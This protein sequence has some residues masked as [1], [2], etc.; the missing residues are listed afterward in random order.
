MRRLGLNLITGPANAGKVALLLRRYL[1]VLAEEPYLIVPNRSDVEERERELLALQP[2]LLAGWIGTFDDLFKRIARSGLESRRVASDSQ[3]ALIVRRAL[4][5]RSLNGLGRS[6][7]FGGF[8]DALLS[9]LGELESGLLDPN[10][11]DGEL[12]SLY[13]AYRAELDR[14]G[15]WDEDLLRRHAAERVANELDAWKGQPVFAY[16]FEDLTGAE[17]ALLQALAG[18]SEVTVSI[19]YEPGRTAFVSLARTIE[20]LAALADGRIEE[21]P[22]AFDRVAE[23][24]L[25]HLERALF[26]EPASAP[27]APPID[28][29]LRFFEGAGRR[30]ALELIGEELLALL[31]SGVAPEQIG[32][33]CPSLERWQAPLETAFG[34]LGVPYA[35]ETY[36]RLD[37]TPYGQALLSVLRF[38]WLGGDRGD[39]Y[40]FLRSPYSGLTRH[41]V[42]FLEGRLRGRAVDSPE[43]VEE[44][45]IRLRDGQPLPVLEAL[46]SAPGP[47]DAVAGLA[48]SM[49]RAAYGLENPPAGELSRQDIRAH[50]AV[51]RLLAE[52]RGWTELD[53]T[54]APEEIVAAVERA[55]VR[56]S[57]AGE[58][59]RIAVIDLLRARTR[60]FEFV[61]L[62]GLE[63][64]SLPRRGHESPFLGDDARRE[65]DG[66]SRARLTRPDQVARDRYL[67]YTACTRATRRVYLARE[68]ATDE[69]SPRE[70]SPFWD[71]VRSLFPKDDVARWTRRCPLSDLAW[72]LEE[73]PTER[74]RLRAV[75]LRAADDVGTA[76]AIAAANGWDRRLARALRAFD[77]PTRITHPQVLA[78]LRA[79]TTFGVTELERFADCSSIWFL[80]RLIDPKSIDAQVDA[81]LRGSIA[82]QVL[83]R[84]F[85][86]LPKELGTDRV[87]RDRVEDAVVFLRRCLDDAVAGVR[88]ELT[89]L[90]ERE[91]RHGLWRDL[92]AFVREEAAS[93]LQLLPRRF[94]VLFGSER[95]AP[96]LQRGLALAPEL[97]L[98][99]KIDRIDVDPFSA[100]GIVQ[101]YKAGKHA[102]SA[103]QIETEKRLQIPLYMLVLR[104]LVGIEPLGGLY[105]PLSGERKAR[106][107]LREEAREDGLPGFA[108]NDYLTE[109]EFWRRVEGARELAVAIVERIRG[110]DVTHDPKGGDCPTW[111]ELAPMC[112]VKRA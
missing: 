47:L 39:L 26:G 62:L 99:G 57:A 50:D 18:R 34:T 12:G 16:G 44:E 6:A 2:A 80:E 14:L 98:S 48:T 87:E 77:R 67:F 76:E 22:P 24:A 3:R 72:T 15:L 68:A 28:G 61:F 20:D 108:K 60:R 55:D 107:L 112:R 88:M 66:R 94:E 93:E 97:T 53:G 9:T 103:Q 82:H 31:R 83:F 84:F 56:R 75:A 23:P 71:E 30:G 21:L 78:E 33:V 8:A 46:R 51:M 17:W 7:R 54:L 74:E 42:D 1:E 35:L 59:G 106:G 96:E 92:E 63:E 70:A 37:K 25:A 85:S 89:D 101:D 86:G 13:A 102:H 41:N 36:A 10:D 32:V 64:G 111:C 79:K 95:S 109:E 90:Q 65:L 43:R 19:P 69:G 81:R 27:D 58:A 11:L 49:L 4:A 73:A 29:A 104:D 38:A 100:R 105:R 52:L 40:S 110:G 5:G 91:L 45:T